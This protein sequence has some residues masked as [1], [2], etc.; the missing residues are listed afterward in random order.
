MII[1]LY[2]PDSYRR[3]KKQ[4][5]ILLSYEKKHGQGGVEIFDVS[6]PDGYESLS[7]YCATQS[8]F[9]TIKIAIIENITSALQEKKL[10]VFL[11][12]Y[13][14]SEDVTLIVVSPKKL[15]KPFAFLLEKPCVSQEFDE[16][17][18]EETLLFV[19]NEA[20]ERGLQLDAKKIKEIARHFGN[21]SWAIASE[22][23]SLKYSSA[24][25]L[26]AQTTAS[27][28]GLTNC[29]KGN[30]GLEKKLPALERLLSELHEDP[31]RIFNG[32]AYKIMS[33]KMA[34]QYAEYDVSIKSG[35]IEYDEILLDYAL[36]D[37]E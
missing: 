17:S 7:S 22:L 36:G 24:K 31:A 6:L 10:I 34:L 28:F 8:I 37:D 1:T 33:E 30:Y 5:A 4:R 29:L 3:I 26:E 14:E 35:F 16:L 11:K 20:A 25:E 2:G 13:V 21:D 19:A 32:M 23:D 9:A 15:P 12:Q 18:A 27:Y